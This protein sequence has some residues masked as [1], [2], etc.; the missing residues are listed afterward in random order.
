M[1]GNVFGQVEMLLKI[2]RVAMPVFLLAL[3]ILSVLVLAFMVKYRRALKRKILQL[4][5]RNVRSGEVKRRGTF[6]VQQ[7]PRR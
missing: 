4:P 3:W 1:P 7:H 6:F 5:V 2:V